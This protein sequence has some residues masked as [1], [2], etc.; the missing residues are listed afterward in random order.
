M[1]ENAANDDL[2]SCDRENV[3]NHKMFKTAGLVSL[4]AAAAKHFRAASM[5]E[6]VHEVR[7]GAAGLQT[8]FAVLT[9][10]P[11]PRRGLSRC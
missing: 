4:L 2:A 3:G 10:P 11:L 1:E 8:A 6:S 7:S 9:P 5:F